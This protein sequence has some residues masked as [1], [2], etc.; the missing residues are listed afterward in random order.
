MTASPT[1]LTGTR[2]GSR[3]HTPRPRTVGASDSVTPITTVAGAHCPEEAVQ[4]EAVENFP[5]ALRIL[6]ARYR[7][8]LLAIYRYA[9]HVDTLGDAAAGDR[10]AALSD[11]ADD[12]DALIAG[13]SVRDPAVAG[14]ADLVGRCGV[15][16]GPLHALIQAN[17][18]DQDTCRYARFADLLG[19]C[20]CSADPVGE[21]VLYAFGCA[22]PERLR[23]SNRICTGLQLLEH[24]QDIGEDYAAGRVYLPQDDLARYGVVESD[25]GRASAAPRL[26]ALLAFETDRA[27]A[28]LD[29]GAVLTATLPRWGRLAVSGYLAGGRA[30]A[31]R[32]RAADYDPLPTPPKPRRRDIAAA[33]A[34]AKVRLPG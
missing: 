20:R 33:W 26:R 3:T 17:L 13:R 31:A 6:P 28:W 19:Y 11:L 21:L 25:L 5:V 9:R 23:L 2:T 34:T 8:D 22:T 1:D 32:L 12:V 7:A 16:P 15:P 14:L 29:A 10:R 30:A 24:W 27:L 18:M 4:E